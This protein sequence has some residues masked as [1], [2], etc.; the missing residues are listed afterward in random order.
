MDFG[1]FLGL[2]RR[3]PLLGG[4]TIPTNT[5]SN[6]ISRV[7]YHLKELV[8]AGKINASVFV[9]LVALSFGL[10]GCANDG[11]VSSMFS[12][13]ALGT[14]GDTTTAAI[15]PKIDP[16]CGTLA[17]QIDALRNEGTIGRLEKV[18]DGKGSNVQVQRT[19]LKKQAELNKANADFQA[20]C[21]PNAP[22]SASMATAIVPP[23]P[24]QAAAAQGLAAVKGKAA[25][26]ASAAIAPSGVTVAPGL[27]KVQ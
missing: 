20:K 26:A 9:S 3:C 12:T 6:L 1:W 18:A 15:T 13:S 21:A 17:A 5:S 25:S 2:S 11:S 19:A 10:G 7:R 23:A 24:A 22:R 16:A 4:V 14:S 8:M 27:P